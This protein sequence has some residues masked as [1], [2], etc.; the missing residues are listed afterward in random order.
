VYSYYD[1]LTFDKEA[2]V[3]P[4]NDPPVVQDEMEGSA[5]KR[6]EDSLISVD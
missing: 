1:D 3:P 2:S 6:K 4:K 5:E